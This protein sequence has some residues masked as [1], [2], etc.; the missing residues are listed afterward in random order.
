MNKKH[1]LMLA[2]GRSPTTQSWIRSLLVL[3]Y[4]VS[5]ISSF[6]CQKL[7]GLENFYVLPLAF[8]H[9]TSG[10]NNISLDGSTRSGIRTS[11]KKALR[12]FAAPLQGLRYVMG[13]LSVHLQANKFNQYLAQVQP[14]LVHALRI[15]FEGMLGRFTPKNIPFVVSTWGNDF[16]LHAE[17]SCFMQRST[18]ACLRRAD[19]LIADAQRDIQLAYHWGLPR[20]K[21][22]LHVPGSSG[23]DLDTILDPNLPDFDAKKWSLPEEK[24]WAVNARGF[25]PGYV[26]NDVFF[27]AIPLVLQKYPQVAFICPGLYGVQEEKWLAQEDIRQSIFLLPKLSQTELWAL[28]KRCALFISPASHD[29]TPN[30]LLEALAC[31]CFPIAGNIDS[32]CEW[33]EAG[34]NGLL[35]NPTDP[36]A[37]ADAII[38]AL[39]APLLRE[40]ARQY[41]L[42]LVQQLAGLDVN[43]PKIEQFYDSLL[44]RHN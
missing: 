42:N 25:R 11:L 18:R 35:V 10:D 23:L 8:S 3:E 6:P 19:A 5:L 26:H 13:P 15:P 12:H 20:G 38:Q 17:G 40:K 1:I 24:L 2:D 21:P 29:G 37:L 28:F 36:Q 7:D 22:T 32:I 34:H 33:I 16:T 30:S 27:A 4:R 31:G 43:L 41:N 9:L 39:N 14:D 44:A